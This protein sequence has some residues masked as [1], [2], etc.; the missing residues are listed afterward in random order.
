MCS[1][2]DI[3]VFSN[4]PEKRS[5]LNIVIEPAPI[6]KRVEQEY[7]FRAYLLPPIFPTHLN[8]YSLPKKPPHCSEKKHNFKHIPL[9]VNHSNVREMPS[10]GPAAEVPLIWQQDPKP[11]TPRPAS[12]NVVARRH[13]KASQLARLK[14]GP[15][16]DESVHHGR[17]RQQTSVR[18]KKRVWEAN[19]CLN[20]KWPRAG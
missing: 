16:V 7:M 3:I 6:Y 14:Q 11:L 4:G 17:P 13:G 2:Y 20:K 1:P 19:E 9:I 8:D 15:P 18:F 10:F 12:S 5:R